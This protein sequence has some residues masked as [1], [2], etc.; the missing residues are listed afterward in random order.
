M[1]GH[2][3]CNNTPPLNSPQY[4]TSGIMGVVTLGLGKITL[5]DCQR[6]GAGV[7]VCQV[8]RARD[9]IGAADCTVGRPVELLL[10]SLCKFLLTQ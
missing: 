9:T 5:G 10:P 8:S 7:N 3:D 4:T 2:L 6:V 1:G